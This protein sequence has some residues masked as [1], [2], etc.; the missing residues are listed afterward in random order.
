MNELDLLIT[1]LI[2]ARDRERSVKDIKEMLDEWEIKEDLTKFKVGDLVQHKKG[3]LYKILATKAT[4]TETEEE[5]VVYQKYEKK[6]GFRIMSDEV[7]CRPKAMFEEKV[8]GVPR[9]V[10]VGS[11]KKKRDMVIKRG[12][13]YDPNR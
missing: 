3:G 7:W 11:A 8:D 6:S 2:E 9:F 10:L 5:L 12:G 4:H 13:Q 1:E